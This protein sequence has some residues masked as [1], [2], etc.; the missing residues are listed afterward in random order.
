M[1]GGGGVWLLT[2][3]LFMTALKLVPEATKR[4]MKRGS[5]AAPVGQTVSQSVNQ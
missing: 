1:G 2:S 4:A 5:A 3:S